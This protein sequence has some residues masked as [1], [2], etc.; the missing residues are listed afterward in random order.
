MGLTS[1]TK[2][3]TKATTPRKWV[4]VDLDGLVLGRAASRIAMILRGKTKGLFTPHDDVG[5]FVVAI[6]A[7]NIRLTGNKLKEKMYYHHS[8]HIGGLKEYTAEKL[9][10]RKPEELIRRAVKGML[11]KTFLGKKQ[12]KK[13]KIYPGA[14][15]PHRAQTPEVANLSGRPTKA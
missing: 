1:L 14:A 15:H 2:S 10:A 7:K 9:L 12:L 13:L 8:E 11:P 3:F 6:N 5:D 4:L